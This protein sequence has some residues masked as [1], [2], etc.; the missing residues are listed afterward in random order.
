MQLDPLRIIVFTLARPW[1]PRAKNKE[2]S[3]YRTTLQANFT[4]QGP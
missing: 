3:K 4:T 1:M 2:T